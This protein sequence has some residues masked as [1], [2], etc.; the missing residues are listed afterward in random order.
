MENTN[1]TNARR[2][3]QKVY[4]AHYQ[5]DTRFLHPQIR[6][7][8]KFLKEFD[9]NIGDSIEVYVTKGK[10]TITKV[11]ENKSSS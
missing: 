1:A 3:K 7:K 4:Y 5:H 11:L 8:G 6:I 2:R 10:I 9:F